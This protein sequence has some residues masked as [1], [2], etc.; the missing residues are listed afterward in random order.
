MNIHVK[1]VNEESWERFK[2]ELERISGSE[3]PGL[4]KALSDAL[5]YYCVNV[6][7]TRARKEWGG[8]VKKKVFKTKNK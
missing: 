2:Q 5:D 8:G 1:N 6:L 3:R 4:G 7:Q